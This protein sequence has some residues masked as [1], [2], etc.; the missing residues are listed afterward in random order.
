MSEGIF[1]K[2]LIERI[3][4]IEPEVRL[5]IDSSSSRQLISRKGLGKAR[6]L[7]V[8]LLW[9]QKMKNV[10]VKP[11][12][13]TENPADLGTK[14][15]SRDKIRKYMKALGY[16]GDFVEGEESKPGKTGQTKSISVGMIA[17]IVAVLMSEGFSVEAAKVGFKRST[18]WMNG[19]F[20]LALVCMFA[21]A[22]VSMKC[23]SA[24]VSAQAEGL[25]KEE[26]EKRKE[27]KRQEKKKK[28]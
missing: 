5:Y 23:L 20:L 21:V 22:V 26:K 6:H 19:F 17:E 7:D 8:N 25:G 12:K 4:G 15:L 28:V 2:K 11:I 16:K 13:G 3:T 24:A 10:I 14:A 18:P 9:I 1:I 27:K